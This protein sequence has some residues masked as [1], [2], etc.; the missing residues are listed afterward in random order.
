MSNTAEARRRM[1]GCRGGWANQRSLKGWD[2]VCVRVGGGRGEVGGEVGGEG[3][4]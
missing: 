4:W 1:S 3:W 2:G